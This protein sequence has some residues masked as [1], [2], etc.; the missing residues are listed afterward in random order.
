MNIPHTMRAIEIKSG[1]LVVIERQVPTPEPGK[2]L[3]KVEATGVNRPDVMQRKGQYPPPF[4]ASDIPGLEVSGVVVSVGNESNL[5]VGDKVCALVTGGGYAEYCLVSS[6]LCLPIPDTISFVEAAGIPEAFFTVWSNIFDR[7]QLSKGE[8]LLVHGGSSGIGTTAIQFARAFGAEVIVTAGSDEKCRFCLD[9][10]AKATINYREKDFIEEVNKLT[11]SAGVNLILDMIGGEYFAKNIQCL[12]P[13]GRL[14]QIAVQKGI[15]AE[16]NL[17]TI[18]TKR[19][20]VT[21]ST[22]RPRDDD[23]KA[24]IAKQLRTH[25]W[26]LITS[27]QIKPIIDSV[28]AIKDAA[29]AHKRMESGE[30]MGKI[31]LKVT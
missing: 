18:M 6:R 31:I 7:G 5:T 17:L 30:H 16:I 25:I 28:F 4:G 27:G 19:L 12:A 21:G 22:L 29:K 9:L 20:T 3:V 26:P 13:E 1:E 10:G 24:E 23:F 8:S 11:N 14:V 2:V 15:K